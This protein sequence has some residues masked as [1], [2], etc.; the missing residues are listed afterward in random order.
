MSENALLQV[1]DLSVSI[2][3]EL[4]ILHNINLEIKPGETHVENPIE[5]YP[6]NWISR[7]LTKRRAGGK[8]P[9]PSLEKI[10]MTP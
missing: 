5:N 9:V 8:P 6:G 7:V 4:P 2:D 3:N 1:K 10:F